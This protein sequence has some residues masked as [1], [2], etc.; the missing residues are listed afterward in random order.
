MRADSK[1]VELREQLILTK[2]CLDRFKHNEAHLKFYSGFEMYEMFNIFYTFLQLGAN[3]LIYWGSVTNINFAI[4]P[5]KYGRSRSLQPQE[6]L[7]PMLVRLRCGLLIEGLS[8][9]FN[10]STS[11]IKR[12]ITTWIDFLHFRLRALTIWSQRKTTDEFMPKDFKELYPSTRCIVDFTEIFIEMS[13]SYRSQSATFSN[14]NHHNIV[15]GLIG[16][17]PSRSVTFVSEIYIGRCSE[18]K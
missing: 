5:S 18:K 10:I 1:I 7:F 4:E 16:N 3:A 8:V 9:R 15:K 2:I 17:V 11:S 6:E 13:T 12:I 14:C